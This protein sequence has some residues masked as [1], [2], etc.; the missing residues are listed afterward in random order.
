MPD[1]LSIRIA[2]ILFHV[3]AEDAGCSIEPPENK[4][5]LEF[6][7]TDVPQSGADIRVEVVSRPIPSTL[8]SDTEKIFDGG[9]AWNICRCQDGYLIT[10]APFENKPYLWTL[11]ASEDFSAVTA[12]VNS[13]L[14]RRQNDRVLLPCPVFYP[15]DQIILIHY[16]ARNSGIIVHCA[17]LEY[18]RRTSIFPGRSGAGKSTVCRILQNADDIHLLSDDRMVIRRVNGVYQAHGTPWPGEAGMALNR[19]S[20]LESIYFLNHAESNSLNT[21]DSSEALKRLFSVASIPWYDREIVANVLDFCGELVGA[22]PCFE[23]H[24]TLDEQLV[25][26]LKES[27]PL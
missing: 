26:F 19:K 27:T 23:L 24:F 11:H 15:L 14:G 16:F 2:G 21:L 13:S 25:N 22:I 10:F 5:Y 3:I 9:P 7:D 17:G 4:A 6:I 1:S 18:N 20:L 12:Y 8:F